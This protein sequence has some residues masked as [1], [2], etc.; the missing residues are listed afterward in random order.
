[1]PTSFRIGRDET[2]YLQQLMID[3]FGRRPRKAGVNNPETMGFVRI[4]Y[5]AIENAQMPDMISGIF[6]ELG[7]TVNDWRDF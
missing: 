4:V 1:L 5:P 6:D 3:Q 2:D 7:W